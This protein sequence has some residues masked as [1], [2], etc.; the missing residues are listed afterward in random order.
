MKV[1]K[2]GSAHKHGA[3]T[4]WVVMSGSEREQDQQRRGIAEVAAA[5]HGAV[6]QRG[7]GGRDQDGEVGRLPAKPRSNTKL[8]SAREREPEACRASGEDVAEGGEV[9]SIEREENDQRANSGE[10]EDLEDVAA[11]ALGKVEH[12]GERGDEAEDCGQQMC[13]GGESERDGEQHDARPP[14]AARA[15][16]GVGDPDGG[17]DEA[18]E[19]PHGEQVV[20]GGDGHA[21]D[22]GAEAVEAER[23]EAA[24]VAEEAARDPPEAAAQPAGRR[25]QTEGG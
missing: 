3:L 18:V 22:G 16:H 11:A 2:K 19:S 25:V 7:H 10:G 21:D 6:K 12:E 17:V 20:V 8:R 5:A 23:E 9:E 24:L 15:L 1:K 13:R 14:F 4:V